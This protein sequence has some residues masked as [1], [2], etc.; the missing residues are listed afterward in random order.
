MRMKVARTILDP[1]RN[2]IDAEYE[3]LSSTKVE[4]ISTL[5]RTSETT[6]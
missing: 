4:K 3:I 1:N 2:Q 5:A 6:E